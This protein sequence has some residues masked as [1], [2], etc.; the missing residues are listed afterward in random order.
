MLDVVPEVPVDDFEH[1][2]VPISFSFIGMPTLANNSFCVSGSLLLTVP[3][4]L[5]GGG[6]S[7]SHYVILDDT[8]NTSM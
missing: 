4:M 8:Y 3:K 7:F 2:V 6:L 5:R 1:N